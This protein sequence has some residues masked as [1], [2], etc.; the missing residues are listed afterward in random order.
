MKFGHGWINDIDAYNLEIL[1]VGNFVSLVV[2][3]S[4]PKSSPY[5]IVNWTKLLGPILFP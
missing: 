3:G 2:L 1:F 5:K 4:A